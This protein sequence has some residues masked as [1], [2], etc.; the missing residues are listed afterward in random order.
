MNPAS[1]I[2]RLRAECPTLRAVGGAAEYD[3][4]A[5]GITVTPA[6]YVV[7]MAEVADDN[8]LLGHTAQRV[9]ASV[10]VLIVVS[11][12]ASAASGLD[13]LNSLEA[14]R[15]AIRSA[16]LNWPPVPDADPFVFEGGAILDFRPGELWWQDTYR[17][18]YDIRSI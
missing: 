7:P 13:G 16:L 14:Y 12:H 3:V 15:I 10:G 1:I 11:D 5:N 8:I 17:T 18:A 9:V 6:A 4:A 2:T